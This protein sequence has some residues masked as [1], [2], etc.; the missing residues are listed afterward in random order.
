MEKQRQAEEALLRAEEARRLAEAAATAA[1]AAKTSQA[2]QMSKAPE[3]AQA[4]SRDEA[5]EDGRGPQDRVSMSKAPD[6]EALTVPTPV[7]SPQEETRVIPRV[8][9]N[10]AT[11]EIPQV[12]RPADETAVL[13]R[14][15][16]PDPDATRE[17]PRDADVTRELPQVGSE[18]GARDGR[19]RP[20]WAEETPMDDLPSL[21]DELLGPYD[22]RDGGDGKGRRGRRR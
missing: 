12:A 17:I 11:M 5:R 4:P 13:P 2:V 6:D 18:D 1:E 8:A 21:A 9:E 16:Q 22:E 15:E 3:P 10:D 7:V 14:I 20:D 19:R